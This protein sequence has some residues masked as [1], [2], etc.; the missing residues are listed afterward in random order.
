MTAEV[1]LA[2][3][4]A[5]ECGTNP[6]V[7]PQDKCGH[8]LTC[9]NTQSN[10]CIRAFCMRAYLRSH[11]PFSCELPPSVTFLLSNTRASLKLTSQESSD[12]SPGEYKGAAMGESCATSIFNLQYD[13]FDIL[14]HLS[15][16]RKTLLRCSC[17]AR[18]ETM[19]TSCFHHRPVPAVQPPSRH[20][21]QPNTHTAKAPTCYARRGTWLWESRVFAKAT[22]KIIAALHSSSLSV[23]SYPLALG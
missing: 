6:S 1:S 13:T 12:S 14:P 21:R 10:A 3:A 23:A 15:R 5:D 22:N 4:C 8:V 11:T 18:R 19:Q 16:R 7:L 2:S 20:H 17:W 9:M